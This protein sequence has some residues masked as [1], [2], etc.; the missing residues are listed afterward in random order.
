VLL[1]QKA[2][3]CKMPN[4][5]HHALSHHLRDLRCSKQK[6]VLQSTKFP[7]ELDLAVNYERIR[8][9]VMKEWVAK[10]I[11]E[12]L[13]IE[14]EVL[15]NMIHNLLDEVGSWQADLLG[16]HYCIAIFK[17]EQAKQTS[18]QFLQRMDPKVMHIELTPFLEKNTT[19]F[20]K[21]RPGSSP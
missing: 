13:G 6:K 15:I 2:A 11:T 16:L 20:M 9:E 18:T 10:R 1:A 19:L 3:G 5:L 7:K 12:L 21:V 4:R 14:E 17:H 8:W